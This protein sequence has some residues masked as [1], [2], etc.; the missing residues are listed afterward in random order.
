MDTDEYLDEES[1]HDRIID[2]ILLTMLHDEEDEH[3]EID[4]V[5]V[6]H[7]EV[8]LVHIDE[9]DEFECA[10]FDD[11]EVDH[12]L[13]YD[14]DAELIDELIEQCEHLLNDVMLL[15]TDEEVV[16]EYEHVAEVADANE[17]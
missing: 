2:I 13:I 1:T 15:I 5:I 9:I 8:G 4:V 12:L 3:D 17:L 10:D 16:D 7:H 14:E 11:D 6:F